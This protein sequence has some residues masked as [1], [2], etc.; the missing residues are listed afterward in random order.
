MSNLSRSEICPCGSGQASAQCCLGNSTALLLEAK[1]CERLRQF[2]HRTRGSQWFQQARE[3]LQ[4]QSED[5]ELFES[6]YS[7]LVYFH[8]GQPTLFESFLAQ[9]PALSG[10]EATLVWSLRQA[11]LSIFRIL[12]IRRGQAVYVQD[13]LFG[14]RVWV[15]ESTLAEPDMLNA[16]LLAR[17][18]PFGQEVV[19]LGM[20]VRPMAAWKAN[21]IMDELRHQ[22]GPDLEPGLLRQW[23]WAARLC[24]RWRRGLQELD[25]FSM[26]LQITSEGEQLCRV[27]DRFAFEPGQA[28]AVRL[29]LSHFPELYWDSRQSAR[30]IVGPSELGRISLQSNALIL[31]CNSL[32]RAERLGENLRGIPGLKGRRRQRARA[33]DDEAIRSNYE[34][35]LARWPEEALPALSGLTPRQAVTTP[36][37]R[38]RVREIL[39]EFE[40]Y[41][42]TLPP[43]Q[44]IAIDDLRSKLGL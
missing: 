28:A 40:T 9:R 38:R 19:M 33:L 20:Y 12:R 26:P 25:E 2:A 4:L 39:C 10:E 31:E 22:A 29:A 17:L 24:A 36:D 5:Q 35:W 34:K 3:D 16:V 23:E 43:T 8:Y 27:R 11:R 32:G 18:A 7:K 21:L 30:W 37:G 41:Q 13:L 42:K 44:S 15:A 14:D 1:F 6:L